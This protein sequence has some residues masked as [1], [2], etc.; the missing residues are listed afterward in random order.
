[1]ARILLASWA[2]VIMLAASPLAAVAQERPTPT[3]TTVA[4]ATPRPVPTA[5]PTPRP[6]RPGRLWP[7][8]DPALAQ[9]HFWL[10]RPFAPPAEDD[11]E[12]WYPYGST[13]GGRYL[14]HHGV[15]IGNPLGT[16]VLSVAPGRVIVAGEDLT[17]TY[18]LTPNFYGRLVIVELNRRLDD[19]PVYVLYGHLQT[20][21]VQVGQEV[22]TG[23][24]IG[25]VGMTGIALGP[26]LHLEVRVGSNT[27]DAARNPDLWLRPFPQQGLIAGRLVDEKGRTWPEARIVIYKAE[28][29]DRIWREL[30]TYVDDPGISPDD[31][32]G[33]NFTIPDLLAGTY[34]LETK[35]GDRYET[36]EVTVKP[37]EI[38]FVLWQVPAA[39]SA[40]P[41]VAPPPTPRPTYPPPMRPPLPML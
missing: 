30:Y 16:P 5:T 28:R 20:I 3:P 22:R 23:D 6:L 19:R 33:E 1:M 36:R 39:A 2:L 9:E 21:A 12:Y 11:I 4:R 10:A 18:G 14:I 26:H 15:D 29:R 25:T 24:R 13:G 41:P 7:S 32:W 17:T 40:F 38:A 8:P 35:I 37:G 34:I 31:A 27:Y